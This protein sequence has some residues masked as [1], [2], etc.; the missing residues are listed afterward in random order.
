MASG[1]ESLRSTPSPLYP[2]SPNE[3]STEDNAPLLMG[4]G[5]ADENEKQEDTSEEESTKA[6]VSENKLAVFHFL[7]SFPRWYYEPELTSK[8]RIFSYSTKTDRLMLLIAGIASLC[9]GVTLPLMNVVF[10]A[11]Y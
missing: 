7:V 5:P 6:Y 10:G 9:T 1:S 3:F 8:Q 11:V 2:D 4:D